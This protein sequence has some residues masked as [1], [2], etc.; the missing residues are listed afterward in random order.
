M[1][2]GRALGVDY[3]AKRIGIAVSD[4]LGIAATAVE[5]IEE[6]DPS[7]VATRVAAIAKDK[8]AVVLVFGMPINMDG[9][10][11]ASAAK[12]RAFA[13]ACGR[14]ANLPIEFVD[15]RLT[16]RQ[17]ERHLW[18]A[19]LAQKGRKA[20][21]DMVAAALLLQ[22]WLDARGRTPPAP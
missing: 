7:K 17:A 6:T 18:H 5:V 15:E 20:R 4:A 13:E 10:E 2:V 12:V 22:S 3:G 16:T 8:G 9:T 21:V 11:H 14:A 1:P 19:G